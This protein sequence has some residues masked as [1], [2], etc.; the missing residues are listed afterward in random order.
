MLRIPMIGIAVTVTVIS[1]LPLRKKL[2]L[3]GCCL[4]M[5]AD[6]KTSSGPLCRGGSHGI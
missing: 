2:L 5:R 1:Q 3:S 6:S 4:V